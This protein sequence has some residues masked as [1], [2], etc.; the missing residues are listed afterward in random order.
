MARLLAALFEDSDRRGARPPLVGLAAPTGKAAARLAE[1]VQSVAQDLEPAAGRRLGGLGASTV[2]RLLGSRPGVATRF[3]HD[4]DNPL[5][6]DVV[7]IDET[8]ML[9]L[10]LDGSPP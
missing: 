1:A 9:P 5:P 3:V 7:V 4:A 10:W 6:Y 8:S 2:H